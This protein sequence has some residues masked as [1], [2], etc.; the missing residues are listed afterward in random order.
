MM[1]IHKAPVFSDFK[2]TE[3]NINPKEAGP[4]L[5]PIE[6]GIDSLKATGETVF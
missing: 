4:D 2:I 5:Q 3:W 1:Y 6:K